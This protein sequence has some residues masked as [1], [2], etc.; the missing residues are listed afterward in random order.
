MAPKIVQPQDALYPLFGVVVIS[1]FVI[2]SLGALLGFE[3][4]FFPFSS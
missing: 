2:A 4:V 3:K 1:A